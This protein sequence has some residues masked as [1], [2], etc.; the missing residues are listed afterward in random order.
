[1][2]EVGGRFAQ[3][4]EFSAF[5]PPSLHVRSCYAPAPSPCAKRPLRSGGPGVSPPGKFLNLRSDQ[6]GLAPWIR[7]WGAWPDSPWIR[8]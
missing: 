2:P 1:M 6:A 8:H 3:V 7:R 4:G 5:R